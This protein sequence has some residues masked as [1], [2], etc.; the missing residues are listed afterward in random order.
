A[1]PKRW[2]GEAKPL[3]SCAG[4][5]CR[6]IAQEYRSLLF[7][8]EGTALG[9]SE[10]SKPEWQRRLAGLLS[11]MSDWKQGADETPAEYFRDKCGIY[12]DLFNIVAT[13]EDR[14]RVLRATLAFLQQNAFQ[15]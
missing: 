2:E 14:L 6:A 13:P 12:S 7:S 8:P 10:R 15:A 11:N 9:S 3:K 4:G 1:T 5:A